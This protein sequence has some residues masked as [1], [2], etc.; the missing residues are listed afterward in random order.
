VKECLHRAEGLYWLKDVQGAGKS[1][2]FLMK[3]N[4]NKR[5]IMIPFLPW[6]YPYTV[7]NLLNP[8]GF[9]AKSWLDIY[10]SPESL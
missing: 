8:S 1:S 9:A 3:K 5:T 2:V 10:S 7:Q 4:P 6:D